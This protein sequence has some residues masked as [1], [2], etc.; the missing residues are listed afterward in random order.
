MPHILVC[1]LKTYVEQ[2]FFLRNREGYRGDNNLL[3]NLPKKKKISSNPV[4]SGHR[5]V[6]ALSIG[7]EMTVMR[8]KCNTTVFYL[9][10]N[11]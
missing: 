6:T 11:H 9:F 7:L 3:L 8:E 1:F 2:S 10:I 5:D 4:H